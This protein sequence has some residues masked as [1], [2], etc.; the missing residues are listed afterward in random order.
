[1]PFVFQKSC[2]SRRDYWSDQVKL[3]MRNVAQQAYEVMP[4]HATL[5]QQMKPE[6]Y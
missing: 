4:V 1:M 3:V 2:F 6:N 5:W